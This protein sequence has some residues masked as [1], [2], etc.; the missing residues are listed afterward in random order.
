[1]ILS[2]TAG[3]MKLERKLAMF[4]KLGGPQARAVAERFW[5]EPTPEHWAEYDRLCHPLYNTTRP[6]NDW[7]S[8][9]TVFK[10]EILFHFVQGE[11]RTMDLLPGLAK[12]Q[13]PVLVLAGEQDPV[14]P[15]DD[16]RDIYDALPAQRR[17]FVSVPNAGHGVWRDDESRAL[18]CLRAF[19]AQPAP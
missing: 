4:E 10:P 16:A 13:C 19:I 2:S 3:N 6:A 11:R 8:R 17:H 15:I 14:C 18:D 7:R 5:N 12:A 1:V 9:R